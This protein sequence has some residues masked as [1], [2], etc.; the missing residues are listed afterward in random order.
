MHIDK[1]ECYE[2]IT[3]TFKYSEHAFGDK[4]IKYLYQYCFLFMYF[5]I[6]YLEDIYGWN[7]KF[8]VF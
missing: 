6:F 8:S 2:E 3:R 7:L 4:L 1:Y 5:I